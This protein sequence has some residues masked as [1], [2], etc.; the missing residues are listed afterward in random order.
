MY[1]NINLCLIFLPYLILRVCLI[2][3]RL[4]LSVSEPL[5]VAYYSII[6]VIHA[7]NVH[8][9]LY[10]IGELILNDMTKIIMYTNNG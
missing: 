9:T 3:L 8:Y 5:V 6:S 2:F 4:I 7:C 1:A 10:V